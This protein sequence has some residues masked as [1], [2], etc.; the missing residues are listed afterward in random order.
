MLF[1]FPS[2][3]WF[4]IGHRRV[5]A[6]EGGPPR[7]VPGFTCPALLGIPLRARGPSGTGLSPARPAF[8]AV[9]LDRGFLTRRGRSSGRVGGSH[10]PGAATPGGLHARGFRLLRFRSPLLAQISV[11]FSFLRV[12][13][14]FSSP[15][16]LAK[17]YV[18]SLPVAGLDP[19]WVPP[20]GIR[21]SKAVCASPRLIAACHVLHRLP[22]PRHPPC[23]LNIF[24]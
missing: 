8:P 24:I 12:L 15:G 20:F 9:P 7:F 18:F 23:A 11:D 19:S 17:A 2:R 14:C 10:N 4:A 16:C 6:L 21:G 13:R 3:Y 1:T 22:M 5:L